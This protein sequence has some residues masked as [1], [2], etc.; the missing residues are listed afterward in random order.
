MLCKDLVK[1]LLPNPAGPAPRPVPLPGRSR[2]LAGPAPQLG[3][4]PQLVPLSSCPLAPFGQQL[5]VWTNL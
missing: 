3:P 4:T 1:I 5:A 2:T